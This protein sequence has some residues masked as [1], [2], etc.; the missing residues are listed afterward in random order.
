MQN[1]FIGVIFILFHFQLTLTVGG[2]SFVI[3]LIPNFV[4]FIFIYKGAKELSGNWSRFAGLSTFAL[5]GIVYSSITYALDLFGIGAGLPSFMKVIFGLVNTF[6]LLYT[7]YQIM[8]GVNDMQ[9]A[10]QADLN[11]SSLRVAW[12]GTLVVAC[13][14][15][16][17][18][19]LGSLLQIYWM[20]TLFY[21]IAQ[22]VVGAVFYIWYLVALNK[23]RSLFMNCA[24]AYSQNMAGNMGQYYASQGFGQNASQPG[25]QSYGNMYPGGSNPGTP[26]YGGAANG[27]A[28]GQGYGAPNSGYPGNAGF[29]G[30][31]ARPAGEAAPNDNRPK[32]PVDDSMFRRPTE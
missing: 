21:S 20:F 6:F 3:G 26:P 32:P 19:T 28:Y 22:F 30:Q 2:M 4:G 7:T 14:L 17:S 23:S 8:A 5:I 11:G 31:P 1:I 13:V 24:A 25:R 12:I 10:F 27:A 16:A 29:P 9:Q 15:C 18:S